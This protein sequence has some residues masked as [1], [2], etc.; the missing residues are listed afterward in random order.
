LPSLL[1]EAL[2]GLEWGIC[3]FKRDTG[4]GPLARSYGTGTT[5]A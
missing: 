5:K 3:I 1:N 2:Q 4:Q